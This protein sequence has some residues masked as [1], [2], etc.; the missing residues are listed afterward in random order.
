MPQISGRLVCYC[1]NIHPGESWEETFDALKVYIPSVKRAISPGAPFP[2]GLRLSARACQEL[3][4]QKDRDFR[5]W[6]EGADCFVPTVNG[7][8]FGSFHG[9]RVK[10]K[11]YLPD[12]RSPERTQ[13]TLRLAGLLAG[14][15]PEGS[16]GSI[17]SVPLGFKSALGAGDAPEIHRQLAGALSGL[18]RIR[19]QTGKKILLAL[20]PEPGCFLETTAEVCEF[21]EGL[22]LP[23]K[24]KEHLGLCYD[25]CHQAVEFEDPAESLQQLL[26]AGVPIAKVQ[27][28]SALK[29]PGGDPGAL[30]HLDEPRYL[31]QVVA[32]RQDGALY[33]YNDLPQALQQHEPRPGDELRCHFHVPIFLPQTP[34]LGTTQDFL[35]R[36]LPLISDDI[37][38]EVETY[39]W[40][41]LPAELRCGTVTES[42]IRELAWLKELLHA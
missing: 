19:E 20:E 5:D 10:E 26:S 4:A 7:F 33:R 29:Y 13:Y 2:I 16:T 3:S 32:R 21:F 35:T 18:A 6:L 17:S 24:L 38:L 1:S 28:S 40:D 31:H 11:V 14:W 9:A 39:T 15:L 23:Q 30:M 27:V 12:W 42:I 25:C 34:H 22:K 41:V 36:F 37:L 8:P